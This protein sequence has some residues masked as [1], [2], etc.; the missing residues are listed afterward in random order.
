MLNNQTHFENNNLI[1]L[2][3]NQSDKHLPDLQFDS[4]GRYLKLNIDKQFSSKIIS[5]RSNTG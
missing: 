1:T 3:E 5:R 4:N 2:I